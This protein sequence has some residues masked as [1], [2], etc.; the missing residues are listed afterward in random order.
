MFLCNNSLITVNKPS[1]CSVY[2]IYAACVLNVYLSINYNTNNNCFVDNYNSAKA[3]IYHCTYMYM[4]AYA[5][6]NK[7]TL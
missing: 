5:C 3:N 4:Y 2:Y 7:K 1:Y 6:Q